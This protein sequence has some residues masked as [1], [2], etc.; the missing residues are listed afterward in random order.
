M[1][2][3]TWP[4]GLPTGHPVRLVPKGQSGD[5][6][7]RAGPRLRERVPWMERVRSP[8]E[9]SRGRLTFGQAFAPVRNASVPQVSLS[10]FGRKRAAP[11]LSGGSVNSGAVPRHSGALRVTGE[12]GVRAF[13]YPV[14]VAGS[15]SVGLAGCLYFSPTWVPIWFHIQ[16]L[17]L[18]ISVTVVTPVATLDHPYS[19]QV[20]DVKQVF[21]F[22]EPP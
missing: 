18:L 15:G 12:P 5:R 7:L 20:F 22:E 1:R 2:L 11:R 14:A 13:Q 16:N 3:P 10:R 19:S 4:D 6:R 8:G 21:N 9:R 17:F